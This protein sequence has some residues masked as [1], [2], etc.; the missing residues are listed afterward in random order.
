MITFRQKQYSLEQRN[1]VFGGYGRALLLGG[2]SG[3]FQARKAKHDVDKAKSEGADDY[4]A[5]KYA[6]KKARKRGALWGALT[7]ALSGAL[8][9][10][11]PGALGG[12]ALGALSGTA[13]SHVI[14]SKSA[15]E[16]ITGK[17]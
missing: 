4:Q 5:A 10:G 3:L 7:G 6:K 13:T 11:I 15:D 17:Q 16:R 14:A 9:G 1:Y 12:A 8:G 2:L